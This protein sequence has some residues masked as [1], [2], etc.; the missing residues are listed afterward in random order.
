LSSRS[1]TSGD[2]NDDGTTDAMDFTILAAH[3]NA[4]AAPLGSLVPEPS[5]LLVSG[6]GLLIAA[7]R[8]GT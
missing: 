2:F 3:F 5:V 1:W 4:P 7:R 8:R 6:F